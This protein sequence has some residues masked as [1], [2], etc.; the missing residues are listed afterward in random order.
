MYACAL[1]MD[2]IKQA[3]ASAQTNITLV[4]ISNSRKW[5]KDLI[6]SVEGIATPYAVVLLNEDNYHYK[7]LMFKTGGMDKYSTLQSRADVM[8]VSSVDD[9]AKSISAMR[10]SKNKKRSS[11]AVSGVRRSERLKRKP[12]EN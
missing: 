2:V 10:V 1:E 6:K 12:G 9:I 8:Q 3:L 4:T 7:Y 5:K 11:T